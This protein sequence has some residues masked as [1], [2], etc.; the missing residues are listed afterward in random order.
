MIEL[1]ARA[2]RPPSADQDVAEAPRRKE[3]A[4]PA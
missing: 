3:H 2:A 4:H 1:V